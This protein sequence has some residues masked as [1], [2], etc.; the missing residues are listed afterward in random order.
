MPTKLDVFL[1]IGFYPN[2]TASDLA[3]KMGKKAVSYNS[4][5]KLAESLESEGL[6]KNYG[7]LISLSDTEKAKL[8][9]WLLERCFTSGV[10]YNV[11]V[12]EK[13][14]EFVRI[15]LGKAIK[16]LPFQARTVRKIS[17][18]LARHGF[19]IIESKKPFICRIVYSEFLEKLCCYF[20]KKPKVSCTDLTDCLDVGKLDLQLEKEYS[21]FKRA[22]KSWLEFDEIG[23]IHSS[24][25]LEG[26]TLTLPETERLIKQ[27]IAPSSKPFKQAQ[28]VLD[29]KKA[30]DG[31]IYS[32]EKTSLENVLEFH[33]IAM[34]SLASGAGQVRKQNVQI[35]G[36][37]DFRTPDW[38][39]LPQYLGNFFEKMR[40]FDAQ[41]KPKAHEL[42][43][44]AAFLHNEFQRIHPF[45]DGN[46]RTSRAIF[47]KY[48]IEKGF[49][50]IKIPIGFMGQYMALTKLS[51]RRDDEKFAILMK[52]ITIECL[53]QAMQKIEFS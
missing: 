25:S 6:A 26:N 34:N 33:K 21:G 4:I 41:K 16:G 14:A 45:V 48:L 8:L 24:L 11:V 32:G 39:Q 30:L 9:F 43:Q 28:Q 17:A 46:S 40:A 15:G 27:N 53:K 37:P 10:D 51:K 20:G 35:K 49:P 52:Q 42:V 47:T 2:S 29:Y 12:S 36:N 7:G 5:Y 22:S 44:N 38:R 13:T 1:A 18:V 50:L 19:A 31:F 3:K 23:F